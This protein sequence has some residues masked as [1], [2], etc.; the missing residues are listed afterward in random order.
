MN[1]NSDVKTRVRQA[2]VRPNQI[3]DNQK[4]GESTDLYQKYRPSSSYIYF[5]YFIIYLFIC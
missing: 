2:A 3:I 5:I 4:V 1:S